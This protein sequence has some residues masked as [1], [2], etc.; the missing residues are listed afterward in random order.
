MG[1]TPIA[2]SMLLIGILLLG[3]TFNNNTVY[4]SNNT[5]NLSNITPNNP[6]NFTSN[7][8][9][10][11]STNQTKPAPIIFNISDCNVSIYDFAFSGR[12]YKAAALSCT[13]STNLQ[14]E[15]HNA[16]EFPQVTLIAPSRENLTTASYCASDGDIYQA[17]MKH[18]RMADEWTTPSAGTYQL[19][20]TSSGQKI[21]E[22]NLTFSGYHLSAVSLFGTPTYSKIYKGYMAYDKNLDYMKLTLVNSGDLPV[23]T[24]DIKATLDGK[25]A[26]VM[27]K[28]LGLAPGKSLT[29]DFGWDGYPP[30]GRHTL[31]VQTFDSPS[32]IPNKLSED[33]LNFDLPSMELMR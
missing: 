28:H 8:T 14:C 31:I 25:S 13:Y 1:K 6:S 12:E 32:G 30:E 9:L 10:N 5:Q 22:H 21:Y 3:C 11:T 16:N 19:V 18:F 29:V 20:V 26:N 33:D 4:L 24:D 7:Y 15:G 2:V 27:S 17:R 23:F